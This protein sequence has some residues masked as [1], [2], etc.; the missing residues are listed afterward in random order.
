M[1]NNDKK[2]E[3]VSAPYPLLVIK[4]G[5]FWRSQIP[6]CPRLSRGEYTFMCMNHEKAISISR[7]GVMSTI[8]DILG[9]LK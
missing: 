3:N 9:S 4:P 2:T 7:V 6:R 5:I 8:S 1:L